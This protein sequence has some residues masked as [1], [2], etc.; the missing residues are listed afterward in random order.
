[1]PEL[2][3]HLIPKAALPAVV[4]L[5]FLAYFVVGPE[6]ATRVARVD[7]FPTCERDVS[8]YIVASAADREARL[9]RPRIDTLKE[10]GIRLLR[11]LLGSPLLD[12]ARQHPFSSLPGIE[13][14]TAA[15][16]G[17]ERVQEEA[18]KAYESTLARLRSETATHLGRTGS[19]CGCMA[20]RTIA[21]TRT[22]W[23]IF[24]GSFGLVRPA[25][26]AAFGETMR[27]SDPDEICRKEVR[28]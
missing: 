14:M 22:E 23:A 8:A 24:A 27:R 17:Y 7:H 10:A 15:V 12:L 4:L 6:I 18:S 26:I 2:P 9:P 28:S 13:E 3:T 19:I 11:D 5:I 25:R 16:E 20:D 1:M 21:E